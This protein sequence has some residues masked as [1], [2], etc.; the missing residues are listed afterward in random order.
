MVTF[1]FEGICIEVNFFVDEV[2]FS[3]FPI[4]EHGTMN[5]EILR[6]LLKENWSH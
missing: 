1:S 4:G 6:G 3:H 5:Q 2:E